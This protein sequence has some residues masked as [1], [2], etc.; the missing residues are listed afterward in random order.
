MDEQ[1]SLLRR[2]PKLPILG[3][4]I[5]VLLGV[6]AAV[7]FMRMKQPKTATNSNTNATLNLVN[8]HP[9]DARAGTAPLDGDKDGLTDAEEEQLGTNPTVSDT[10]KDGLSDFDEVKIY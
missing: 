7:Y 4:V 5:L 2:L 3:G 1:Q 10:D 6:G 8:D 9:F